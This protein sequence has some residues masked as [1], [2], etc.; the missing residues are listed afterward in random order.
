MRF[1]G[2]KLSLRK[3]FEYFMMEMLTKLKIFS[4]KLI[5]MLIFIKNKHVL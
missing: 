2:V 1:M 3:R 5:N 4:I